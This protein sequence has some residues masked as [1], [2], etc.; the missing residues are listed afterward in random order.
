M[1]SS[2]LTPEEFQQLT[3]ERQREEFRRLPAEQQSA[4]VEYLD[5]SLRLTPDDQRRREAAWLLADPT[6]WRVTAASCIRHVVES[7]GRG[8]FD[9]WTPST[10]CTWRR[11]AAGRRSASG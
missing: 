9:C 1:A 5:P 11:S 8:E 10:R 6:V 3:P 4:V 2:Y 7:Y